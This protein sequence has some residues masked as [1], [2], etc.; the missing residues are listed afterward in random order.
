M[1]SE[2]QKPGAEYANWKAP[3]TGTKKTA[4]AMEMEDDTTIVAPSVEQESDETKEAIESLK[5]EAQQIEMSVVSDFDKK[6]AMTEDWENSDD[7]NKQ[8]VRKQ[9]KE[10]RQDLEGIRGDQNY[11][12]LEGAIKDSLGDISKKIGAKIKALE[13]FDKLPEAKKKNEQEDIDEIANESLE[14]TPVFTSSDW[15]AA[16]TGGISWK[17][18]AKERIREQKKREVK[19]V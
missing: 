17:S 13:A 1:V 19:K 4:Q 15:K 16:F 6:I 3:D 2:F 8:Y 9:L 5:A 7:S 14:R 12:L 18:L 10:V 11:N